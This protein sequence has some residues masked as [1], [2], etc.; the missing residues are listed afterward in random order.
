MTRKRNWLVGGVLLV[1]IFL[2]AVPLAICVMLVPNIGTERGRS[3]TAR[4]GIIS[5]LHTGMTQAQVE[6]VIGTESK[7]RYICKYRWGGYARDEA[8]LIGSSDPGR[9][10]LLGLRY[11]EEADGTLILD[12]FGYLDDSV[13]PDYERCPSEFR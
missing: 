6:Q 2:I 13:F 10:A 3:M 1:G 4:D 7:K 5:R 11:R 12:E 9:A 8:L